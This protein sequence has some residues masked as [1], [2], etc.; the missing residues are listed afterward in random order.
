M[1]GFLVAS[2]QASKLL[3]SLL[4]A[5]ITVKICLN[6]TEYVGSVKDVFYFN[7]LMIL[8]KHRDYLQK[9]D[10]DITLCCEAYQILKWP[11]FDLENGLTPKAFIETVEEDEN[12]RLLVSINLENSV[13]Q[14]LSN[15][16]SEEKNYQNRK[17]VIDGNRKRDNWMHN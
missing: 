5:I 17:R 3:L 13:C 14:I 1:V 8:V 2:V 16:S 4:D 12:T 15:K 6:E 9:V 10:S 11:L 7:F